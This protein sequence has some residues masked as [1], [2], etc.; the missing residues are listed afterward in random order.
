LNMYLF[1]SLPYLYT[2]HDAFCV[3]DI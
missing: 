2:E 1:Q 3:M